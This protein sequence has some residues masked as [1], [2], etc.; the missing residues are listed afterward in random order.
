[1]AT[2]TDIQGI[3]EA[4]A[5]KLRAADVFTTEGLLKKGATPQGRKD[6]AKAT[7]FT[8]KQILQWV[9][10][11]DLYRISGIGAQYADLLEAAGVDTVMELKSRKAQ[12]L[13]DAMT[14]VNTKKNLVNK[15]P[16]LSQVEGW[17]K[18][19]KALKRAVEY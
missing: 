3:G 19:A 18:A 13:L 5:K 16:A 15:M 7:G 1:M 9:N 8:P 14:A 11:A 12:A 17:I 10:H 6:L 2:I 4:F